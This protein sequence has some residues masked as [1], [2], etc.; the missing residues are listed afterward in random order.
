MKLLFPLL[1]TLSYFASAFTGYRMPFAQTSSALRMSAPHHS[2]SIGKHN[3]M[4]T[5]EQA[6][7]CA[8]KFDLCDI[9]EMERLA[10][11]LEEFQGNFFEKKSDAFLREKEI[12]DRQDVAEILKKQGELRLRMEYLRDANLFAKDVHDVEDSYPDES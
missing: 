10:E 2:R 8:S 9:E 1:S 11:E 3:D 5:F 6:V 12:S 7:E 4:K